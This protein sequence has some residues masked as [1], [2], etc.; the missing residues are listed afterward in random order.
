M[1]PQKMAKLLKEATPKE[2]AAL[3]QDMNMSR[4]LI[5]GGA[6]GAAQT[7]EQ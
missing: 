6:I 5:V 3:K 2:A 7:G 1:N 4:K